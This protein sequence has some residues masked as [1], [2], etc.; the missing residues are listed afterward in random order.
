[1]LKLWI[2]I[3]LSLS[4]LSAW[5]VPTVVVISS[6]NSENLVQTTDERHAQ[7]MFQ[8]I[9][10]MTLKSGSKELNWVQLR[11]SNLENLDVEIIKNIR[12][13]D[14][15]HSVIFLG[16][17]NDQ[18]F[19]LD[20]QNRMTG[21]QAAERLMSPELVN[22]YTDQ[23]MQVYFSACSCGYSDSKVH[24]F[25]DKFMQKAASLNENIGKTLSSITSLAHPNFMNRFSFVRGLD[26]LSL[27]IH[28]TGFYKLYQKSL[29]Q[30][31]KS[32]SRVV[33]VVGAL[34][35]EPK[36]SMALMT[37]AAVLQIFFPEIAP[38]GLL[39]KMG[40]GL[41][42]FKQIE[43]LQIAVIRSVHYDGST[44]TQKDLTSLT[45]LREFFQ[46]ISKKASVHQC[47]SSH[48]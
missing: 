42:I 20:L 30:I 4:V 41:L 18:E 46:R 7:K 17:G 29:L 2:F 13:Q 15:I 31:Q 3:I 39:G 19:A 36:R 22:R 40:A 35:Q 6:A 38:A 10:K 5:A 21:E 16:H 27:M 33:D 25:Q 44:I 1:M 43:F 32:P 9:Q 45:G 24:G 11:L 28:K 26:Y 48:L 8:D 34:V 37:G 14:S 47:R 12:P 23:K